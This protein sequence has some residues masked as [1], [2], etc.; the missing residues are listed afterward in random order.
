VLNAPE[1]GGAERHTL[2]L[3]AALAGEGFAPAVFAMKAG[4]LPAPPGVPLLQPPGRRALPARLVDLVRAL[5]AHEPAVI[6]AVNERPYAAA[7]AARLL[8][9]RPS[10]VVAILHA[11]RLR[12]PREARMQRVYTPIAN[13]LDAVVFLARHQRAFWRGE[14]LAPRRA[15][16]IPNGIDLA[17]FHP[18]DPAA[19]GSARAAH[20][21]A[22]DDLVVG[23]CAVLRPEKNHLDLVEAVARLRRDGRPARALL[24]GDG[25]MRGAI[26]ARARALEIAEHVIL[27][28]MLGDVRPA[29]A[30][31]DLGALCTHAETLPLSALEIMATGVPMVM[32]AG[33]AG[34]EILDGAGGGLYPPGDVAALAGVLAASADSGTRAEAGRRARETVVARFDR[35]AMVAAYAALLHEAAGW[36]MGL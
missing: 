4:P 8:A 17:R 7:F 1:T 30:A 35:R 3:A 5:R 34:P 31:F 28:G 18:P 19:R 32:A 36:R 14:G 9:R 10:P 12:G 15:A 23:C 27:A 29:L 6:V 11:S 21:L 20:G 25:P 22:P 24:V 2:D 16:L 33:G 26:E 13:R